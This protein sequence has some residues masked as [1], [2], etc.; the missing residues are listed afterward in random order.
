MTTWSQV[1]GKALAIT[2]DYHEHSLYQI[3]ANIQQSGQPYRLSFDLS[4]PKLWKP[5]FTAKYPSPSL[6]SVQVIVRSFC[7]KAVVQS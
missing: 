4:K 5:F 3:W 7:L 2:R 6:T 1:V